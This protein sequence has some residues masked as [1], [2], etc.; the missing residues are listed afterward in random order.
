[1]P[2]RCATTA[3]TTGGT[4]AVEAGR[5]TGRMS[6]DVSQ[7]GR[8]EALVGYDGSPDAALAIEIGARLLPEL[9]ARIVHLWTPP[10][11]SRE[12]RRRLERRAGSIDELIELLE[13][14]GEAEAARLTAGG[15]ALAQAAGWEATPLLH[16]TF[17][18]EGFALA[19]LA[20][21]LRPAIV[22]VGSR[23]LTGVRAVLG[24]VSDLVVHLSPV[25]VLVVPHPLPAADREAVVSGPVVVGHDA[26]GG[27]GGALAAASALFGGR[28]IVVAT[29]DDGDAVPAG[30]A[31]LAAA[32]GAQAVQLDVD[33][34]RA[35]TAKAVADTLA[36]FALERE[37]AAIVVG[38]RGRSVGKELLLGS[39][40]MALLHGAGR[41]VVVVPGSERLGR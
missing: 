4:R 11:S 28:R 20:E 15:V 33:G 24:S 27:A 21:Q 30:E 8:P 23:G 35:G 32:G 41:P 31:E 3:T 39:V 12:L 19:H 17:G 37:A 38:S 9:H 2:A 7:S 1:M 14:E 40:A 22:V 13:R 18:G 34:G 25:P 16:R 26:S 6:D 29:V 10:F 5:D 36:G